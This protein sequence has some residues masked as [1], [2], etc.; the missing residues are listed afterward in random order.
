MVTY[1][2]KPISLA[3]FR[4]EELETTKILPNTLGTSFLTL[5]QRRLNSIP[6][7][8]ED[9]QIALFVD[10]ESSVGIKSKGELLVDSKSYG[11][12][13]ISLPKLNGEDMYKFMVYTLLKNNFTVLSA[14]T[15]TAIGCKVI[16]NNKQ[17][18]K[19]HEIGALKLEFCFPEQTAAY[20]II[21]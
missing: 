12:F 9:L 15:I 14:R 11:P 17:F 19:D 10:I 7:D 8:H 20:Q 2:K 13:K 5:F 6:N 4:H 1:D 3:E 18:F 16:A 21:W